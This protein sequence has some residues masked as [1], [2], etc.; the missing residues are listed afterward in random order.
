MKESKLIEMKNK[1][2][3]QSRIMQ[4]LLNELSN[5]RDLAIGTLET[6]ELIPGYDDA[7]EQIKKDITKKSSETKKIE[8]LEK[9]SN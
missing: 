9:T 8:S 6:L 3:A 4:H 7:I 2:D 1:I 5:V